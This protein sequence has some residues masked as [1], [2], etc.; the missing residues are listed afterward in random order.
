MTLTLRP[1]SVANE[2]AR[3]IAIHQLVIIAGER[4]LGQRETLFTV[5]PVSSEWTITFASGDWLSGGYV[6]GFQEL[7]DTAVEWCESHRPDLISEHEQSLKRLF[8]RLQLRHFS[9]PKDL[10][11]TSSKDERTR[12]YHHEYQNKL[13]VGLSEFLTAYLRATS[14]RVL[15]IDNACKLAPTAVSLLRIFLRKPETVSL[16]RFVLID[17][18]RRLFFPEA[19]TIAFEPYDEDELLAHLDLP[20]DYPCERARR[21]YEC[22]R[23]NAI[24]AHALR[25][26][27][28]SG[29]PVIGYFDT[30]TA[31]DLYLAAVGSDHRRNLLLAY[32]DRNCEGGDLIETRNYDTYDP[33]ARDSEHQIRHGTC[34]AEYQAGRAPLVCVHAHALIDKRARLRALAQSS[35]ILQSIGLYDTWF[36]Y[37]GEMFADETLRAD[38]SGDDAA[39]ATF[40]NAAFV[41]YSLG[42]SKVSSPF[43]NEFH[44][45]FPR[46]KFIPTVLYAQSMTY[47]RYQQPVDL[48][49]AERYALQNLQTIDETLTGREKYHYIKVFAENAYAYIKARQGK[50][51]EAL[52]LCTDGN[53]RMLAVYGEHRFRLHQSILIYNTSQVYELVG[54]YAHAEVQLRL[55]IEYDPYYGEYYNDLGNLLARADPTRIAEA[56]AAYDR[57]I[58]LCPPYYEA[59]LNRGMLL[60]SIGDHAGASRDFERALEI[61]PAEWRALFE[62]GN[63]R[64]MDGDFNA[65]LDLYERALAIEPCHPDLHANIGVAYSECG[66]RVAAIARYRSALAINST[67][68]AAHSNLAI[69]LLGAGAIDEALFHAAKAAAASDDPEYVRNY[70][71]LRAQRAEQS[72]GHSMEATS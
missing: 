46:S 1:R 60:A 59:H 50:F 18:E 55:A 45:H 42:C 31:V 54:D 40:I 38:G 36:A 16:I 4:G 19:R 32:L 58:R 15:A 25:T 66:D 57:A 39:N 43:L 37:F 64:L 9:V 44:A 53:Q 35:E 10:T 67:H 29:L 11:N 51:G 2:I 30:Q 3:S 61:K 48:D 21:L 24:E 62:L 22:S 33:L 56:I 72:T 26:C 65:A 63:V 14:P 7:L 71:V 23:G 52:A 17:Y 49:L 13:L 5:E 47:G 20:A 70:N 69:E 28:L 12:F 6:A 27:E 34:M 8:P 41:L 68:A